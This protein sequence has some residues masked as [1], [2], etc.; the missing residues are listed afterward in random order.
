METFDYL[1]KLSCIIIALLAT[2]TVIALLIRLIHRF[3]RFRVSNRK[4]TE[5]RLREFEESMWEVQ[6]ELRKLKSTKKIK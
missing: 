2:A 1:F 5:N 4:M 3:F 6:A